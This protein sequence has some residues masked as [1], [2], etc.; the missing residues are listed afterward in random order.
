MQEELQFD[1][2]LIDYPEFAA[3]VLEN[4]PNETGVN[5]PS[6]PT[7]YMAIAGIILWTSISGPCYQDLTA[8]SQ[9]SCNICFL[10]DTKIFVIGGGDFGYPIGET[11]ISLTTTFYAPLPHPTDYPTNMLGRFEN[12]NEQIELLLSSFVDFISSETQLLMSVPILASCSFVP[13]G[14]GPPALKIPV[15]ALTATVTTTTIGSRFYPP[16]STPTPASPI[17]PPIGPST[18]T[19]PV[20]PPPTTNQ[21]S[22]NQGSSDQY[23]P[24]RGSPTQGPLSAPAAAVAPITQHMSKPSQ[25]LQPQTGNG[26]QGSS[27]SSSDQAY[28]ESLTIAGSNSGGT[29]QQAPPGKAGT[30][31]A[32]SYAGT[33]VQSDASTQYDLP[34]IGEIRPGGPPITTAGVIYSLAPLG[35]ELISDGIPVAISPLVYNPESTQQPL[36][37]T[38]DGKGYTADASSKFL[39]EG[40]TL[41][42]GRPAITLSGKPIS[43]AASA[44]QAI[45]GGSTVVVQPA[46]ITPAPGAE[47]VPALTFAGSTY[48]ANLLGHFVIGE[49]TLSPGAAI[50]VSGTQ[51]SLAAA[52]NA[53]VIG[54]STENLA[55]NGLRT[56]A[57]LSF[58][59]STFT[60]DASSDFIIGGQTLIP[61]GSIE[62]SGTPISYPAG[63]TAVVI[64]T[65]TLPL[66]F[67]TIS[68]GV[69]PIITFDGSTFTADASSDFI[70]N[71]Q[72]LTP[73]GNIDISGTPILYPSAGT[74]LVIGTSTEVFSFATV[75]RAD[76]PT[77]TFD[78]STYTADASSDFVI[79]GQTLTPG[80]VITINGT[81]VSYAPA[82]TEVVIGSSTEAVG[83]GNLIMSGLG[84]G[85]N[86]PA[87]TGAVQF[88]GDALSQKKS[89]KR[90]LIIPFA[91]LILAIAWAVMMPFS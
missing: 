40:Q 43:L 76:S 58:D 61:G 36:V 4:A 37:S 30:G 10:N 91:A 44:S 8:A 22:P 77:I 24:P 82:G 46:G 84:N 79:D 32:L 83:M 90:D 3:Y 87:N 48:S 5:V 17:E 54:S 9:D 55:L 38:V 13:V 12:F 11:S 31:S 35:N 15:S 68:S 45:V 81:P 1:G 51:I 56:A 65:K 16:G 80:G 69:R 47:H 75:T 64:G 26:P 78:G 63:A 20:P 41:A 18:T 57:M 33:T 53:A 23:S 42:P 66:S 71:G 86:G 34:G 21:I 27:D 52:G 6:E 62:V 72:T 88:T 85:P 73:G 59:G 70:I 7:P 29:Q 19:Q 60:A 50:T 74:A 67:G 25:V 28:G 89:A 2:A 14:F 49:Q 39:I